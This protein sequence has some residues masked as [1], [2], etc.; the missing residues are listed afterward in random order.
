MSSAAWTVRVRMYRQG[1]GDCF[2]ITFRSG[3]A[4]S[5]MLIDCGVLTGTPGG[6]DRIRRVANSVLETTDHLDLLV[7]THEHWDHLSGFIDAQTI[8]DK[9][10]IDEVW[11][12][13]TEDP[14]NPA[15]KQLKKNHAL[16]LAAL[17]LAA[18]RLQ[19]SDPEASGAIREVLSF[20]GAAGAGKTAAAM[21]YV[22]NRRDAKI[23]Y[24]SPDE[25]PIERKRFPGVRFYVLGPPL[26]PKLLKKSDPSQKNS[27]VYQ[28]GAG[29][30]AEGAF[31]AA[32]VQS[33]PER[34]MLSSEDEQWLNRSFPF[35][36]VYRVPVASEKNRAPAGYFNK[37][38]DWRRIDNDWLQSSAQLA[39]QLDSDTNNTSLALAIEFIKSGKVLLFPGDAQVGNWLSWG[40]LEWD[41][42]GKKVH[43]SDLLNRTVLYK[44]GHHGSHNAT[45]REKGLEEMTSPDLVAMI[46]VDE[47]FAKGKKPIPWNMPFGSLYQRLMEKTRGRILRGDR[48]WPGEGAAP[49]E[50]LSAVEWTAFAGA[51]SVT[52]DYLEFRA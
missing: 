5:H 4:E 47:V 44:V 49:P 20:F 10:K 22:A 36:D 50:G 26:D 43:S 52:E 34:G 27:E 3:G 2:L 37:Q 25:K 24:R 33:D 8:F 21:Q 23:G 7:I 29:L 46:P 51:A 39:L 11:F 14:D 31:H 28:F 48:D 42:N 13:W 32:V 19:A 6:A 38:D 17:N 9:F 12:G 1:L 16:K 35:D 18:N 30:S 45:L 41:V 15:A 40:G